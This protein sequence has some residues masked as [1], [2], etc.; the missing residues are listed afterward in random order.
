[1]TSSVKI[2]PSGSVFPA[3]FSIPV[4]G[5]GSMPRRTLALIVAGLLAVACGGDDD[6]T[7][8]LPDAN[9]ISK[10][11][12]TGTDGTVSDRSA[13][14]DRVMRDGDPVSDR[15]TVIDGKDGGAPGDGAPIDAARCTAATCAAG[16]WCDTADGRCVPGCDGPE[17]CPSSA[18]CETSTHA[19]TC[20]MSSEH[21]CGEA[22]VVEG[23]T[24][25]GA[26]CQNCPPAP[27]AES[28]CVDHACRTAC[29]GGAHRC[30]TDCMLDDSVLSCGSSCSACATGA[31]QRPTCSA[32]TCG[33]ACIT[34]CGSGCINLQAD[35]S[36]CGTCG[37]ACG[38]S[39][40]CSAGHC[41][42]PCTGTPGFA[43][44]LPTLDVGTADY[45]S[46]LA[47]GDFNRDNKLDVAWL[48]FWTGAI[49]IALG[50]G[51]GTLAAPSAS[52][53]TAVFARGLKAVDVNGDGKLDLLAV[54]DKLF[55]LIGN[56]DGT[57]GA[58]ATYPVGGNPIDLSAGD[59]NGDGKPD[60]VVSQNDSTSG[61]LSILLNTGSGT[62]G[63]ATTRALAVAALNSVVTGDFNGDAKL[64]VAVAANP[65][66]GG[67]VQLLLGHGDGTL[68]DPT[69]VGV[70]D[71]TLRLVA[72]DL[73]GDGKLDLVASQPGLTNQ[74]STGQL[75]LLIGQGNGT[76][77]VRGPFSATG[78]SSAPIAVADVN[79]DGRKDVLITSS[80][81][82][83][84]EAILYTFGLTSSLDLASPTKTEF[85]LGAVGAGD[86]NGDG[87]VDAVAA[88]PRVHVALNAGGALD[89]PPTL[90][91]SGPPAILA[92]VT[93]DGKAD[94]ITS[95]RYGPGISTW[96]SCQRSNG[97]GTFQSAVSLTGF[98]AS[99]LGDFDGDKKLDLIEVGTT[100]V[101]VAFGDGACGFGGVVSLPIGGLGVSATAGDVNGDGKQDIAVTSKEGFG[102][103]T[104]SISILLGNGNRTFQAEKRFTLGFE[105]MPIAAGD[106]NHDGRDDVAVGVTEPSQQG[107]IAVILANADGSLQAP[108]RYANVNCNNCSEQD[109][110]W[111]RVG[112]LDA[113]G[114]LDVVFGKYGGGTLYRAFGQGNGVFTLD[115]SVLI[116]TRGPVELGDF[117]A[118]GRMD[119]ALAI[120]STGASYR[121]FELLAQP[122]GSYTR[123]PYDA[124]HDGEQAYLTAGDV[125]GDGKTDLVI[126]GKLLLGSCR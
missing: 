16:E 36:N 54:R 13:V 95:Y 51:D 92:D 39:E 21:L 31:R 11:G 35:P 32:A 47:V 20:A 114:H 110:R 14:S 45:S 61:T 115:T 28:T 65:V 108:T 111:L 123:V 60:V 84:G 117:N 12:G 72:A 122:D 58:A 55:V 27:N 3:L 33:L 64:D 75:R 17:D 7:G 107:G 5:G 80:D 38:A 15:G 109:V 118:D 67:S 66:G 100:E 52:F 76:F 93:G 19:C 68:A 43:H 10:D 34:T 102:S 77:Q 26:S 2:G 88:G 81:I 1:M 113:D 48:D 69:I 125:N 42:I 59:L 41:L 96:T 101:E 87:K 74:S 46:E 121:F 62:F 37:H 63:G 119:I 112:D 53:P 71:S 22:C 73:Q 91:A 124:W 30:G 40:V 70:T 89:Q 29:L 126:T 78:I 85:F 105:P 98:E 82:G 44:I 90:A 49:Q 24:S 106:F 50:R 57:F 4:P 103:G 94:L 79:G 6:G 8:P 97:D 86:F 18:V 9:G 104:D 116:G 56:G 83:S 120:D 23:P 25:C 99:A